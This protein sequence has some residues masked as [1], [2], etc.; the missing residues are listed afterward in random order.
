MLIINCDVTICG[1]DIFVWHIFHSS[2]LLF[3]VLS[4]INF[5]GWCYYV[6]TKSWF[7]CPKCSCICLICIPGKRC[8]HFNGIFTIVVWAGGMLSHNTRFIFFLKMSC[9]KNQK[10][11]SCY[12]YFVSRYVALTFMFVAL[13]SLKV[14]VCPSFKSSDLNVLSLNRFMFWTT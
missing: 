7:L 2:I 14:D 4:F 1:F 6:L 5:I 11:G 12:R 9:T 3:C 10:Y 8:C 13:Q